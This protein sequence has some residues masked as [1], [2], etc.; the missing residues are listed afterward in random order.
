MPRDELIAASEGYLRAAF[1]GL[2]GLGQ[3]WAHYHP[4]LGRTTDPLEHTAEVIA[5][6]DLEGLDA[7]DRRGLLWA[8]IFHDVGKVRD[9]YD[10]DHAR[11]SVEL[12]RAPLER[13]EDD[14]ALRADVLW[15]VATH[16]LLG[17]LL[18]GLLAPDELLDRLDWDARLLDLHLRLATADIGSIRGLRHVVPPSRLAAARELLEH[19]LRSRHAGARS[20]P[21]V[22]D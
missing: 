22:E 11:V 4:E 13:M 7:R 1:P 2:V 8:A 3:L 15:L 6:L 12:A 20:G 18:Q 17:R 21:S 10:R 14:C 9:P 5:A 16:D 19:R